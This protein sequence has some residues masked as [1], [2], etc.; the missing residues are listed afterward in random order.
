MA[1]SGGLKLEL[2]GASRGDRRARCARLSI[3]TVE[4]TYEQTLVT[5]SRG[6]L[7]YRLVAGEY[8]LRLADGGE[9]RFAVSDSR[10]TPVHLRIA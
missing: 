7:R 8:R 10:W 9:T 5:D 3:A 6:R 1:S 4:G 2:V